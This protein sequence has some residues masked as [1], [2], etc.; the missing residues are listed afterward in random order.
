MN[1]ITIALLFIYLTAFTE[2]SANDWPKQKYGIFVHYGWGGDGTSGYGCQITQYADGTYPKSIDEAANNFDVQGFVNDI[3]KMKPEYLI[4][5]AWHCGM[6]PLYPSAKMDQWLGTG[7]CSKRDVLQE[8]LNACDA[9]GIDV[10]FYIQ[11]SEAHDFSPTEQAAVGYI[12]RN[13]KTTIYNN[14]I[15]E[16]IAE[17]TTRY[18]S[19]FKGFWFD[20]GLYYRCTDTDR[21]GKTVRAIMPDAVLIANTFAG[22]SADYGSV[23]I[24]S[25]PTNFEGE[26]YTGADKSDEE[27][28][29]AFNRSISFVADR[30][31]S[32][33]KGSVRYTSEMMYKY[34]VLEAGAN[35]EGGGVA[36]ALGP[37]PTTTVSWN[38]GVLSAM[39]GL[40]TMID[41]VGESIKGT[42]PSKSWPTAEGT[43]IQDLTWG[44]ATRSADGNYEYLHVLKAPTGKTLT[45]AAP[46][47][48]KKFI[49]GINLRTG[50]AVTINQTESQVTI[51]LKSNDS[52]D[53]VD[54]V[55]KL[56]SSVVSATDSK[57]DF[58]ESESA[59]D[60][61]P[62]PFNN[63][64][65]V[66]INDL[67][68]SKVE[69]F[70]TLGQMVVSENRT[71]N[72]MT[73]DLNH[74][75][76]GLYIVKITSDNQVITKEI[77][78]K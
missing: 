57:N 67:Q 20:K 3:A 27:T 59:I 9:K 25:L 64:I 15:N 54:A 31:W 19:Q 76:N 26:G 58:S 39:T 48:G 47:D 72:E 52:W 49:S 50:K 74:V 38:N 44:V 11:P 7:H 1:K 36:W 23:E 21:I 6:N 61:F 68:A 18:K 16:V 73:L 2:V 24:M 65:T 45:I 8:V 10:Y 55:I 62:N 14:F 46:A 43:R 4:F 32:S 35:T 37:F 53:A 42:V 41:A 75:E 13:T 56:S 28:W 51:T 77:V 78:K 69:V 70:N 71:E 5:T 66:Q 60:I 30:A 12:D 63:T 17:L 34:T 33:Q 40:G 29:P 22:T